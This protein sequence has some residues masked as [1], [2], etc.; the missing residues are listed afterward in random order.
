[1]RRV[2]DQ[3]CSLD[4]AYL[5]PTFFSLTQVGRRSP[6]LAHGQDQA[7][8]ETQTFG[9]GCKCN[10]DT[11]EEGYDCPT[12]SP[13]TFLNVR[14]PR[15]LVDSEFTNLLI[16]VGPIICRISMD[17]CRSFALIRPWNIYRRER[18]TARTSTS[19]VVPHIRLYVNT[20]T[21]IGQHILGLGRRPCC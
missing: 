16:Q 8:L 11:Q 20:A 13:T 9:K 19:E 6:F 10:P 21:N 5:D 18:V 4:E 15:H 14:H 17:A 1:M 12:I 7:S 2:Q 3:E